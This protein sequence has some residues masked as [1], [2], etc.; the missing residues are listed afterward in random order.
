MRYR[1][2]NL[3]FGASTLAIVCVSGWWYGSVRPLNEKR[4]LGP[5]DLKGDVERRFGPWEVGTGISPLTKTYE[6]G[7]WRTQFNFNTREEDGRATEVI[8]EKMDD[9]ISDDEI[10][11]LLSHQGYNGWVEDIIPNSEERRWKRFDGA[12]ATLIKGNRKLVFRPS[13]ADLNPN[14]LKDLVRRK[15]EERPNT[16]AILRCVYSPIP[17]GVLLISLSALGIAFIC[18]AVDLA[19]LAFKKPAQRKV[20]VKETGQIEGREGKDLGPVVALPVDLYSKDSETDQ[21]NGAFHASMSMG[22]AIDV[23]QFKAM[24]RGTTML[25]FTSNGNVGQVYLRDGEVVHAEMEGWHGMPALQA[26][27][28]WR[29]GLAREVPGQTSAERSIDTP[30]Q[31]LM[32]EL[33]QAIDETEAGESQRT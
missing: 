17:G 11:S 14:A 18:L 23:I 4:A 15:L 21:P 6:S 8:F 27:C 31:S 22:T 19:S 9:L 5:G 25:E 28:T 13:S 3:I 26:I 33:C 32:L 30:F 29:G 1:T 10:K 16:E 7:N 12:S 2:L 20:R 24:T